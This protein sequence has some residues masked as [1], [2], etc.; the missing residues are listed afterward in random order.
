MLIEAAPKRETAVG[1]LY[2]GHDRNTELGKI[3]INNKKV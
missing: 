1:I 3:C 2:Y